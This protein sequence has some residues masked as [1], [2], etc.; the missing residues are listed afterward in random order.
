[1]NTASRNYTVDSQRELPTSASAVNE[2]DPRLYELL[3]DLAHRAMRRERKSHTLEPTALVHEAYLRMKGQN[4]LSSG[5]GEHGEEERGRIVVVAAIMIRRVLIDHARRRNAERRGG[6]SRG[7]VENF[8]ATEE[9]TQDDDRSDAEPGTR[10]RGITA[11]SMD[12][13]NLDTR[14]LDSSIDR[15]SRAGVETEQREAGIDAVD[16]DDALRRLEQ[17]DPRR[18]QV[19]Q[20]RYYG[21]LSLERAAQVLGVSTRTAATDWSLARA[22]LRRELGESA[23]LDERTARGQLRTDQKRG[24]AR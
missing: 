14:N 5:L 21:G 18:A 2:I 15:R 11:G 22:W 20:L 24:G 19:V 9:T 23:G 16:F 12:D 13:R 8:A 4:A 17:L 1:M 10:E 6:A 3:R 7:R